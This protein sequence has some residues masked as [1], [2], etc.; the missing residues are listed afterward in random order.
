MKFMT[1][2]ESIVNSIRAS[3]HAKF[4]YPALAMS[5]TLPDSCGWLENPTAKSK[6][7]YVSWFNQFMLKYY[8]LTEEDDASQ[9]FFTQMFARPDINL[10]PSM[11]IPQPFTFLTSADCYAL[12]CA[13]L[14]EGSDDVTN[15]NA[16]EIL[17]QFRFVAPEGADRLHGIRRGN[18][19]ILQTDIFC[20]Q[21]CDA[22]MEWHSTVAMQDA[23][24]I[25][26]MSKVLQVHPI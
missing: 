4:W 7:R 2:I 6:P 24:I 5:L 25:G 23:N 9:D 13:Y 12:R 21:M 22:V 17:E 10:P 11:K 15:Q 16:R 26:R 8:G 18:T 19:L 1:P 20:E 3:L 14:H